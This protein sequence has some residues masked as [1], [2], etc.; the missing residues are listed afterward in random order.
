MTEMKSFSRR[1]G[2]FAPVLFENIKL[3]LRQKESMLGL[4]V[5]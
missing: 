5:R 1:A 4:P 3:V 2:K